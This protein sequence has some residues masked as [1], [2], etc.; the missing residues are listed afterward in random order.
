MKLTLDNL[1]WSGKPNSVP[2]ACETS[3]PKSQLSICVNKQI[4]PSRV[5]LTWF[6]LTIIAYGASPVGQPAV[7]VELRV[8]YACLM[9]VTTAHVLGRIPLLRS[10]CDQQCI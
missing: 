8:D 7:Y 1:Y 6:G 9:A 10:R 4:L 2:S 5:Q 3:S